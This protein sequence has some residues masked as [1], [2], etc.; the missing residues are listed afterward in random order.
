MHR[1]LHTLIA[2]TVAF[3]MVACGD[4]EE[5][6]V[7]PDLVIQTS[8]LPGANEG[9]DYQVEVTASGGTDTDYRWSLASGRLPSGVFLRSE[10]TPTTVIAGRPRAPG[11]FDFSLRVRDSESNET[12]ENFQIEVAEAP[13]QVEIV[14]TALPM[15]SLTM[16][17][18]AQIEAANGNEY[19]WRVVSGE[20]PPGLEI[21]ETGTPATRIFGQPTQEG[22]YSFTV[23][24]VDAAGNRDTEQYAVEIVD[25]IPPLTMEPRNFDAAIA[26]VEYS[27][28]VRAD[29]G[30]L[31]G[32]TWSVVGGALPDGL[33]LSETG[34][35]EATISGTPTRE[36]SF[37]FRLEVRDDENDFD[38][39]AYFIEVQP[40]PPPLRITTFELAAGRVA[41]PYSQT[42]RGIGG[43]DADYSW[44]VVSGS[45][46]PGLTITQG[47]PEMTLEGTPTEA[48]TFTFELEL[49]NPAAS[50]ARQE[51]TVV[52]EEEIIPVTITSTATVLVLPNAEGGQ[53]YSAT[54][55][56]QDGAPLPS[57]ANPNAVRY[58]WVVTGGELPPGLELDPIG[59]GDND[60]GTFVGV[61]SA[62]GTYTA[63]VTVF[64][65][66]NN[67]DSQIIEITVDPPSEPL[68]IE[69]DIPDFAANGCYSTEISASGGGNTGY[70]WEVVGGSL[71]PG[72]GL[73]PEGTP[74]TVVSG[75]FNGTPGTFSVTL[76]V[77]DSFGI[78]ST[79]N[80]DLVVDP[81]KS[82]DPRWGVM[83]G[84]IEVDNRTDLFVTD[85]CAETPGNA[86][87]VNLGSSFEDVSF[88]T[89][90][91]LLS[92]RGDALAFI[93]DADS[94]SREDVYLVDLRDGPQQGEAVRIFTGSNTSQDANHIKWSPDG[95]KL[96]V[97]ADLTRSSSDDLYVV[98]LSDLSSPGMP[99]QV[100]TTGP[101][102]SYDVYFYDMAFSPDGNKIAWVQDLEGSSRDY[103]YWSDL[104]GATPVGPNRVHATPSS[105]SMDVNGG[106]VWTPDSR[107]VVFNADFNAISRDELWFSDLT[108]AAPY[109]A[110]V[111]SGNIQSFG[112]ITANFTL[113][114][115]EHFSFSPD[116]STL[117]FMGDQDVDNEF[118]IYTLSYDAQNGTFAAP[119]KLTSHSQGSFANTEYA[120]WSPDSTK[121][122]V[123]GDY[124]SNSRTEVFVLDLVN[125][126]FPISGTGYRPLRAAPDTIR[127]QGFTYDWDLQWSADSTKVAFIGDYQVSGAD[128]AYVVDITG[129][130]P[131]TS[132][133]VHP[134]TNSSAED[135]DEVQFSP[136]GRKVALAG[137]VRSSYDELWVT[138]ISSLPPGV[139]AQA[140][141]PFSSTAL[142]VQPNSTS[143]PNNWFWIGPDRLIF[144]GDIQTS[145]EDRAWFVDVSGTPSEW[146]P[147]LLTG[148]MTSSQDVN[149]LVR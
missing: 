13:P 70:Q 50:P 20:L 92:P 94:S 135:V 36:G 8:S 76:Q 83:A 45:L 32:Y 48:D 25:D 14:T 2:G 12:I 38:R 114:R 122:A 19:T 75:A 138:D 139:S 52:I 107:G 43:G 116:G 65:R 9:V 96:A 24:V 129:G 41:E 93:S 29:G 146:S 105:T 34:T 144:R 33:T 40:A 142:D 91:V 79:A 35:P 133:R 131:Y 58:N 136:D 17:Y 90:D 46:P 39:E 99:M 27:T 23:R 127:E 31:S 53:P 72:F 137:D 66:L 3:S 68:V 103:I 15:G 88:S 106:F 74:S 77:T 6:V 128:N 110:V 7:I 73:R 123:V 86:V 55:A 59:R 119:Q 89:Q 124:R 148:S 132:Y 87:R 109:T 108:G 61:P 1:H 100:N 95:R 121:I 42:I 30:S 21:D 102:S 101:S 82:G 113:Y 84:D 117:F 63:T 134:A 130:A 49:D 26:G 125:D 28:T 140:H 5:P 47:T 51:Y 78:Q 69:T 56:A 62:L 126:T 120:K 37:S 57:G 111:I 143:N 60:V 16:P 22:R 4:E 147:S 98:D 118:E 149:F 67:T 44:S 18:D 141:G 112:D 81:T 97:H 54:L 71:P 11:T 85:L 145:A 115:E 10:G 104:S 64:D 80:L